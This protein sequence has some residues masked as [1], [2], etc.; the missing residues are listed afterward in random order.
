MPK[1][2][3]AFWR[4]KFAENIKRDRRAVRALRK[5]GWNVL[6]VWECELMRET[7]PTIRR[8]VRELVK[9]LDIV[10]G[11]VYPE[12]IPE[13]RKLLAVAEERVRYRIDSYD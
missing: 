2:H 12:D 7:A 13:R 5:K 10:S 3:L 4:K 11:C 9:N 6:T 8:V 1:T